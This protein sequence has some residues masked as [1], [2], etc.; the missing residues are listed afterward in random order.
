MK[1][2]YEQNKAILHTR[3]T[4]RMALIIPKLEG[5][6]KWLVG[7][8]LSFEPSG[9][10]L[11]ILRASIPD[12][13]EDVPTKAENLAV[14][15]FFDLP[16]SIEPAKAYKPKTVAYAH[17]DE[18]LKRALPSPNFGL[19]MEQGTGKTKVA[20][21]LAGIRFMSG[22]ITG[23]LVVS[24]K[25]VHRQWVESQLKIH[26]GVPYNANFWPFKNKGTVPPALRNRDKLA[27]MTIN[28]DAIKTPAGAE[29]CESFIA[30]HAGRVMMVMDESHLIKNKSSARWKYAYIIG[31]KA[32]HRLIMTGTPIAKDLSDEWSQLYWLD[33][34]ILGI[35]YLTSFR[36]EYCIMG[37]FEGREV[38]AHKNVDRFREKVAPHTYRVTKEEIGILPK[39]YD[40]WR[41]DLNSEQKRMIRE[42]KADLLTQIK[43]GEIVNAAN[44]AVRM[45]RIQ[46]IAN[47]FVVDENGKMIDLFEGQVNNP[48]LIALKEYLESKQGKV[49]I[50]C[51]FIRDIEI[52]TSMLGD[53]C[54]AYYGAT[55]DD[56][57]AK[58][59]QAFMNPDG[60]RF[61]VSNPST[62]GT[63][64]NLQGSCQLA[65]YY[66]NSENSIERWQSEDRI[67]RIGT[68]GAVV[69]TDIIAK[70]ST[71]TRILSNLRK[72][73]Q[74]SNMALSD[75]KSWL[76]KDWDDEEIESNS[77]VYDE[78]WMKEVKL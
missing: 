74:I 18:A 10:N 39:A 1:I 33:E 54:V 57:R 47:G 51:R 64:L 69:Y 56:E 43:S 72:K 45:M 37:G 38:L 9:H 53:S 19:F 15:A 55:K 25:G 4:P 62:G 40:F 8:G 26:C 78:E 21:D 27:V 28:I 29:M 13:Q 23:L 34:K 66:S 22:Q 44:A 70:G 31:R 73:K 35:R 11:E 46:Q 30:T 20:I 12:L 49:V 48:R 67:H 14:G 16:G 24:P 75:I 68:L 17:Q 59:V 65:V 58:A 36:N 77:P 76:K 60:P 2:S 63:G 6:R 50:W 32:S 61:F 42:I 41:F 52:V 5:R 7:G 71:D 3:M